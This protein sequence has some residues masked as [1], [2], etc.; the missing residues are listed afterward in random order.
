M[1]RSTLAWIAFTIASVVCGT[2]APIFAFVKPRGRGMRPFARGWSRSF[3]ATSG[4]R[5]R[6][7]G[8]EIPRDRPVVYVGN[9]ESMVD[10]LV[11]FL[12]L[13]TPIRFLAKK[14]LFFIPWV[15]WNMWAAGFVPIDRTNRRKAV[16]ALEKAAENMKTGVPLLVFPEETRSPDGILLP[17]Q[18]GGFMLAMRAGATIIP[19]G[20]DGARER[21]RK[22]GLAI[23][24][25]EVVVRWGDPIDTAGLSPKERESVMSKTRAAIQEL[26][27]GGPMVARDVAEKPGRQELAEAG[28]GAERGDA[29]ET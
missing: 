16:H 17:F 2:L 5:V 3:L 19:F 8:P 1:L 28:A 24:P 29:T 23:T 22:G 26:R 25:G 10:I 14:Q 27:G 18:K 21:L 13:P 15:G 7:E 9:H 4:I 11:L 6:G 20:I 12:A